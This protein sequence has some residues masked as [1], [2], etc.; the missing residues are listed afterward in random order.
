MLPPSGTTTEPRTASG[1]RIS[2]RPSN[3]NVFLRLLVALVAI[4]ALAQLGPAQ[5]KSCK[6]CKG[7]GVLACEEHDREDL[8]CEEEVIYCSVIDGCAVCGGTGRIPCPDCDDGTRSKELAARRERID[9]AR[10]DLAPI[11]KTMGRPLRKGESAH[12]VLVWDTPGLKV[13]KKRLSEHQMLHLTLQRLEALYADYI[14]L[15]GLD[16]SAFAKKSRVFVWQLPADHERGSTAFCGLYAPR[17][18]KLMGV[19]PNYSVC[20]TTAY[21]RGDEQLH[22]NLVHCVVHLLFSHDKPSMWVGN[23]K[24]GWIEEGL[25]HFFEDRIFG[26]CDT[27]CFEEQNTNPDFKGGKFKPAMRKMVEQG[28]MP[29]LAAAIHDNT[30]QLETPEHALV[31]AMVDYLIHL[32]PKK[33]EELG[34]QLRSRVD[35]REALK[36]VYDLSILD[37]ESRLQAW[38]KETYPLE[39]RE[40]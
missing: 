39:K 31:L 36:A 19:D 26:L 33:F 9:R 23:I 18:T 24:G 8:S 38:V 3:S 16:D 30:T 37:F 22:R 12:F 2:N 21:F 13:E 27:Y 32:D 28:I 17:G 10:E 20:A 25:A 34:K 1:M 35:V 5:S 40:R 29:P 7:A 14:Q 4:L 6:T 11:D 15:F